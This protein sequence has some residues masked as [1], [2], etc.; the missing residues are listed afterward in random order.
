[1]RHASERERAETG[2]CRRDHSL[3]KVSES[4]VYVEAS[5]DGSFFQRRGT[6]EPVVEMPCTCE[7]K[8]EEACELVWWCCD[9]HREMRH[10]YGDLFARCKECWSEI[11]ANL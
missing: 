2:F 3:Q 6:V 4:A 9:C 8:G 11:E 5:E 10:R 1:M 7:E